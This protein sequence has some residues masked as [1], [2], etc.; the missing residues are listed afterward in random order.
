[1]KNMLG[2]LEDAE[3]WLGAVANLMLIVGIGVGA[4]MLS[5]IAYAFARRAHKGA[6]ERWKAPTLALK[7]VPGLTLAA[8]IAMVAL[9]IVAVIL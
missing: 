9:G 2:G 1:M 5:I 8:A 3:F 7:V 6:A 4:A